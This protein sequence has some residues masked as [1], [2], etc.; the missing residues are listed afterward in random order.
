MDSIPRAAKAG[1]PFVAALLA[2]VLLSAFV[3]ILVGRLALTAS[4]ISLAMLTLAFAQILW[5]IAFQWDEVTGGSN[6]LVGI[7]PPAML[8]SKWA[9]YF[10][11][12]TIAA[13][14]LAA[15]VR[16]AH[17]PFGYA[18]R[19]TRDHVR[20]AEAL[21][22][23][24]GRIRIAAFTLS[25][26][27]AGLGGALYVFSKGSIAPDVLSIPRSVDALVM[28]LLGGAETLIGPLAGAVAFNLLQD[29]VTR[30]VPY[31]QALL[32]ALIILLT[33]VFPRGIIGTTLYRAKAGQRR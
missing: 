30:I 21:G 8:A 14:V 1:V 16:L 3:A 33:L 4:G 28:V 31:W 6:G 19:A 32:G 24:A 11:A 22:L 26:A 9:Y 25:G 5:A 13:T 17:S 12:L 27:I 10:V 23:D 29:W 18:L 20:R 2:G 7:W 15:V